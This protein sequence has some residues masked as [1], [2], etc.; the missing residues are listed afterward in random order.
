[1]EIGVGLPNAIPDVDKESLLAFGK[2]ADAKGFASL[3]T[4][5][6]LVYPGFEP[7]ATLAAVA[8]VTERIRLATTVILT[9]LRSNPIM[10]AKECATLDHLS[11]GRF[12]LGAGLGAREDDYE[13]SGIPWKSRGAIFTRQ[14]EQIRSTWRETKSG[15]SRSPRAGPS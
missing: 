6:R 15:P 4:V 13:V 1:M 7:L 10:L 14:L 9:P 5:D 2:R 11:D 3:G 8:A 12:W